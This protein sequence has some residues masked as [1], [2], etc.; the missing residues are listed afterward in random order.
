[1]RATASASARLQQQP[2]WAWRTQPFKPWVAGEAQ[3][4][5]PTYDYPNNIWH[6]YQS[7]WHPNLQHLTSTTSELLYR[8]SLQSCSMDLPAI[9]LFHGT[10][11]L[12]YHQ[13]HGY[14]LGDR[15]RGTGNRA[16]GGMSTHRFHLNL[17]KEGFAS[18]CGPLMEL[19]I[20]FYPQVQAKLASAMPQNGIHRFLHSSCLS[21]EATNPW[22]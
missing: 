6:S 10:H 17:G 3:H 15:L 11:H 13:S 20:P 1:M 16:K 5:C 18:L 12:S 22:W 9:A 19:C 7:Y 8:Q 14:L 21:T 2:Q 4:F